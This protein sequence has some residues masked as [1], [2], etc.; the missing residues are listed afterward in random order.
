MS[1][2]PASRWAL[3]VCAVGVVALSACGTG[4]ETATVTERVVTET[5]QAA[6]PTT[7]EEAVTTEEVAA[8]PVAAKPKKERPKKANA[9]TRAASASSGDSDCIVLPDV[10][11]INHQKGQDKIRAKGLFNIRDKDAT[12][13]GR[14]LII[15]SNWVGVR[16]TPEGGS[17]VSPLTKITLYAKKIGE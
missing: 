16:Q 9:E 1:T 7:T 6:A 11:G 15:D 13:Q 8:E 10:T 17:C 5:V 14:F 12:G 4:E 2:T 3:A